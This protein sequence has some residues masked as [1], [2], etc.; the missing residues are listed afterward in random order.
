MKLTRCMAQKSFT[1]L[2]LFNSA[3]IIG[4][5]N[6]TDSTIFDFH[7]NRCCFRINSIFQQ[8]LY[9]RRW[10]VNNLSCCNLI[11]RC[12]IEQL[13]FGHCRPPLYIFNFYIF[14]ASHGLLRSFAAL[15][16]L[17]SF[18]FAA[19][20]FLILMLPTDCYAASPLS[21]SCFHSDSRIYFVNRCHPHERAGSKLSAVF[22]QAGNIAQFFTL[23]A[24]NAIF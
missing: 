16:I 6:K 3:A 4:N 20:L 8:L 5:A 2:I 13:Y 10:S 23:E 19:I 14:D 17:L 22:L 1:H 12:L 9:N 11:N 7:S 24:S 15:A 21:Q 18:G